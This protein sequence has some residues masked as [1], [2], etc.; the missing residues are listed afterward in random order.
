[1]LL[2]SWVRYCVGWWDPHVIAGELGAELTELQKQRR[3]K[4][5][6]LESELGVAESQLKSER[7]LIVDR[8]RAL[9]KGASFDPKSI[10]MQPDE[11][12]RLVELTARISRSRA[13]LSS[14]RQEYHEN[15]TLLSI[16]PQK[17]HLKELELRAEYL[18]QLA[19]A[20]VDQAKIAK[21]QKRIDDIRN[22]L[23]TRQE[24]DKE[25]RYDQKM[26]SVEQV[27]RSQAETE[28]EKLEDDA[29]ASMLPME[30][31][32]DDYADDGTFDAPVDTELT[33]LYSE[34]TV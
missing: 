4:I 2:R 13:R 23:E 20:G 28:M 7:R 1:M 11:T 3:E 31:L 27:F 21:A 30:S 6:G 15:E 24:L 32:F 26:Q 22:K 18:K 16:E 34:S 8:H 12:H 9:H 17:D 5:R 19:R 14:E 33:G 25:R 10:S 29:M